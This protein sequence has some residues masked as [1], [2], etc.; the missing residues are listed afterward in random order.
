MADPISSLGR[1]D[2]QHE[3]ISSEVAQILMSHLL[4]GEYEP[5]Q[6]LPSER[7]LATSLGVGRSVIRE[8][9]KSLTL[10]GLVQVRPG[11]GTYLQSRGS[12]LLPATFEWGL[13]LADHQI[14]DI[15]EARRELEVVLAAL[16]ARRRDEV[17]LVDLRAL[18]ALMAEAR[19]TSTFARADVA[20]HLRIAQAARSS[21]LQQMLGSTQ[22]MLHAWITRVI[23]AAED[24]GPSLHEHEPILAA[25]EKKSAAA[26]RAAMRDHL[27][28]AG[29]RLS[30]TL[31]LRAADDAR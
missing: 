7:A 13:L 29:E 18:L 31:A 20:F 9:L 25:I 3:P 22:S 24:T 5:G 14:Q 8:A 6:R 2:R 28:R 11:D 10:L 17:D 1:L 15:I 26:A 4:G 12:D 23:D 30:A 27:N 16:A 19:D 21:V